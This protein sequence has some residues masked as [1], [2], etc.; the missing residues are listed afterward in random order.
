MSDE[1]ANHMTRPRCW[2]GCWS[3]LAI[4]LIGLGKG[5]DQGD[6]G[7]PFGNGVGLGILVV[8]LFFSCGFHRVNASPLS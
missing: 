2:S 6:G 5:R 3:L 1:E 8:E 4:C 7:Y